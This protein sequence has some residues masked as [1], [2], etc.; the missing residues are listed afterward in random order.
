MT[1]NL[2]L[3]ALLILAVPPFVA[4]PVSDSGIPPNDA[5]RAKAAWEHIK[6]M[7]GEWSGAATD[8]RKITHRVQLIAAGS[9]VMEESWF[10]GHKGEMMVTTYYMDGDKLMLTHYCVAKNAPRMQ[11]TEISEDGRNVL[12]T[13]VDGANIPTRDKGHMD[14]ASYKFSEKGTFSS[15]WTW[16]ANGKEQWM[17]EFNFSR[18]TGA[19]SEAAGLKPPIES[20]CH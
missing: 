11:A 1:K 19:K 18:A 7:A 20:S 12:F 9:V 13:F 16:Y 2:L 17:E 10:E 8:G 15:R 5:V 4:A 3:G 14:K 6:G